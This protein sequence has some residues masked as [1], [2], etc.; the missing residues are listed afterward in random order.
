MAD[1][2]AFRSIEAQ[3][4]ALATHELS[5]AALL[6]IYFERITRLDPR[7]Q[8]FSLLFEEEARKSAEAADKALAAGRSLGPLHGLPIA[9]K[10]I[11]DVAGHR[12][13]AGSAALI[14]R[15]PKCSATAVRRLETAGAIILGKTRM[16]EFAFGGWGTNPAQGTP[17]NPWDLSVQRVPGGSSSGS[18]VAVAAGLA[19]AAL[20]T[21]TGGS[22]RT[23]ASWCGLVGLKTSL[24][25]I[26]R[27]GVVPLCPTHDTVGPLTRSVRDAALLLDV[28]SG[29]DPLDPATEAAPRLKAMAGI[30]QG[31]EGLRLAVLGEPDLTGVDP[32][33]RG[34]FERAL[35]DLG[36]LG[37]EIREFRLPQ[38][39][40]SYLGAGGDIMS[41]ESFENLGRYVMPADSPVDPVIRARILRGREISAEAYR[42]LLAVRRKAQAAFLAR[43]KGMDALIVP[44]CHQAAIPL[45]E[46]DE[47]APPNLFGRFVNFLDLAG[48]ALPIG[49]TSA[50]LPAGM[51]VVVRRYDDA[52]ALRIGRAFEKARGGLVERPA[53]L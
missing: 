37:A 16:V 53:E 7:L 34:L 40:D 3:A 15:R 20:G 10:D 32:A 31:I 14:D 38:S 50:G 41:R 36:A 25:L 24:G 1:V 19:G 21:D 48:L 30:E 47:A 5:S 43:F 45:S 52:L 9:V 33:I 39:P 28:L 49:V 12:T 2:S 6:D 35:A 8:A 26:G 46:V 11:F 18:A 51:Q 13:T 42:E 23:P 4:R 29:P 17:W 27:G 22:V 44:G